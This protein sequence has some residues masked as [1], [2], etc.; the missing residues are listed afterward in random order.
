MSASTIASD[1]LRAQEQYAALGVDTEHALRTLPKFPISI[2]CWQADDVGG[3]ERAGATLGGGGIQ[4]TGNY[5]GKA[6]SIAEARQDYEKVFTLVPGKH[7]LNLHASY[8]EFSQPVDR[9]AISITQFQGWLDWGREQGVPLDFNSTCFSHPKAESGF[10]LSSK[11]AGTREFWIEHVKRCREIGAAM[12]VQQKSACVHNVWIPDGAK[13]FTM[14]RMGHRRILAASLDACFA[15]DHDEAHLIDAVESKLF[16]IGSES[17]VAGSHE[18]YLGYAITRGKL[19]CL[20]M[21]HFHPTESVAD[22]LSSILQYTDELLLHVSRP[23]RWDSDHVVVL[24]D[25]IRELALEIVRCG[26]SANFRVALDFFD[27]SINR[28]GA[29]VTGIRATLQGLLLGLLEPRALLLE[30]EESGNGFKKLGL[31]ETAKT[32]PFGAVWNQ[33]CAMHNVPAG[34]GWIEEVLSYEREVTGKRF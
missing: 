24:D 8:G 14:D 13:D 28:V 19:L 2:H 6:R 16:G 33:Y 20:D 18:F 22:K 25:S 30:A 4:T 12:G 5:P 15:E 23:V 9:D 27:A 34:A 26:G 7:R 31:L 11:D 3:F 21:G 1:Y 10:T 32:L 29:Y 17:F